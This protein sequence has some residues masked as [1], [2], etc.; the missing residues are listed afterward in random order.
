MRVL[1]LRPNH[2]R[3]A[4]LPPTR[5]YYRTWCTLPGAANLGPLGTGKFHGP[6]LPWS[7]YE[8][9][10]RFSFFPF[11]SFILQRYR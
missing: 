9:L 7:R 6:A 1:R 8:H 10:V 4:G 5:D 11:F 3:L 2:G